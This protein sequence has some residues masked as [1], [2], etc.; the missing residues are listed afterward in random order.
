MPLA[1][2]VLLTANLLFLRR[3][4]PLPPT[5]ATLKTRKADSLEGWQNHPCHST[6]QLQEISTLKK[7]DFVLHC[8]KI[9]AHRQQPFNIPRLPQFLQRRI[10]SGKHSWM[11]LAPIQRTTA[12]H[13]PIAINIID[14]PHRRPIFV[15]MLLVVGKKGFLLGIRQLPF[16]Q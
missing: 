9:M 11:R 12:H 7:P 5:L 4:L 6:R 3:Y 13:V 2:T 15:V 1:Y 16:V 10:K 8:R 14:S